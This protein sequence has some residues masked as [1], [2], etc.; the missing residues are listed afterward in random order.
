MKTGKEDTKFDTAEIDW[1]TFVHHRTAVQAGDSLEI[2]QHRFQ[3]C[4]ESFMAVLDENRGI[5]LCSRQEIGMQLGSKYGFSLFA[6]APV[7]E[8]MVPNPL[9][10]RIRQ[11]WSEVL[12]QVFS[13]TG[14]GFFDDV[15]LVDAGEQF[16]GL[17]PVQ[18]L[19]RLQTRLLTQSIEQLEERR[20]EITLCN[21]QMTEELLMARE[22]QLAM[23]SHDLPVLKSGTL[24]CSVRLLYQYVP[25][26]LVSGDFYEVLAISETAVGLF[27]A[28]VMGHGVQAALV[29]AMM[30]ALI[31]S[32]CGL[33][34][35]PG[36][37]L[38]AINR[39][40]YEIFSSCELPMFISGL[41]L[42]VDLAD[43]IL[44]YANAGHPCPLL[45]QR[46]SNRVS[47]LDCDTFANGGVLGVLADAS[48]VSAQ[49]KLSADDVLL[50]F[51]DGLFEIENESGAILGQ[52]GLM[53]LAATHIR[54]PA[55]ILIR[56]LLKS[57]KNFSPSGC[58]IDD[59]CVLG[60]EV[61]ATQE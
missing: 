6:K 24:P 12:H 46:T 58:F 39:S 41:A 51:T 18:S 36:Q 1:R 13:R 22:M 21:R 26:G 60:L 20:A 48:F 45:L 11:P 14:D 8:Y 23:L 37:F 7:R 34:A 56:N 3:Q 49:H 44:R 29:T 47:R 25:L 52:D 10:I 61:L 38:T 55:D 35:D 50:L 16:L 30:R 54:E 4:E 53:V 17:I 59:V 57:V 19:V 28:D 31:Q 5:G 27:I 33:T 32:H 2:V 42:V 9:S 15:L 40:L 43:G